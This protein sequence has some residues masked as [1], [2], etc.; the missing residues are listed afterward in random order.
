MPGGGT[1]RR[2]LRLYLHP[3]FPARVLKCRYETE[4]TNR[5][6]TMD[7]RGTG[8]EAGRNEEGT[9]GRRRYPGTDLRY[10]QI[11]NGTG[12]SKER[13]EAAGRKGVIANKTGAMIS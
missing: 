11:K 5:F 9:A 8:Q 13:I 4:D 1:D 6:P 2:Q 12:C 10:P 7:S 3:S